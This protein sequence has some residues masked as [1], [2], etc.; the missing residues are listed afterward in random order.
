MILF[1]REQLIGMIGALAILI[2]GVI[3]LFRP[4]ILIRWAKGTHPTIDER[5][6]SVKLTTRIIAIGFLCLGLMIAIMTQQR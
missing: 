3:F 6:P 4:D 2:P 5:S 1:N